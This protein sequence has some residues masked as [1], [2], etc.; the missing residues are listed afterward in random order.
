LRE[1]SYHGRAFNNLHFLFGRLRDDDYW[2]RQVS[3][4][5]LTLTIDGFSL[6]LPAGLDFPCVSVNLTHLAFV[7]KSCPEGDDHDLLLNEFVLRKLL[8]EPDSDDT[9][10]D[11][12]TYDQRQPLLHANHLRD[13]LSIYFRAF[14]LFIASL[15]EPNETSCPSALLPPT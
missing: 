9:S 14:A 13:S 5:V 2:M 3:V 12:R 11:A 15:T 10:D 4:E 8:S 6:N 7:D 1:N